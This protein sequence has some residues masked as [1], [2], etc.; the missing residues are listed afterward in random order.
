V[1][2]RQT[3]NL[4]KN[5][6]PRRTRSEQAAAARLLAILKSDTKARAVKL[7]CVKRSVR[8]RAYENDLKLTIAVD[9]MARELAG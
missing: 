1:N 3:K 9:R 7:K 6:K 8:L 5:L 2:R 4:T